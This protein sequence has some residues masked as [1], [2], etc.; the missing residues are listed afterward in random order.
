MYLMYVH[1]AIQIV[2]KINA[3]MEVTDIYIFESYLF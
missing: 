3:I 1:N 2:C